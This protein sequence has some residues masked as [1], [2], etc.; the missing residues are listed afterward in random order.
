[1]CECEWVD[2]CEYGVSVWYLW[3][4]GGGGGWGESEVGGIVNG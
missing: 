4:K 1:M 3:R 2:I